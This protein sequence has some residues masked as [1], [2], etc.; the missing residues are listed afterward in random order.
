MNF[1]K[2][3]IIAICMLITTTSISVV[4][5]KAED[6]EKVTSDIVGEWQLL[7]YGNVENPTP[8]M[9]DVKAS[10]TFKLEGTFGGNVG[11][12]RFGGNYTVNDDY[13]SFNNIISTEMYCEETWDQEQGVLSVFSQPD[14]RIQLN[15]DNLT[16]T[17]SIYVLNLRK[18]FTNIIDP[19]PILI[20]PNVDIWYPTMGRITYNNGNAKGTFVHFTIDENTGI[21]YDYT[22]KLTFYPQVWY[23]PVSSIDPYREKE[24]ISDNITYENKVI[25]NSIKINGFEPAATPNV[26]ADFLIFQGKNTF[27]RF[28]DQEGGSVYFASSD[29]NTKITFEIPDGF[30]ISKLTDDYYYSTPATDEKSGEGSNSVISEQPIDFETISS[31]WQTIWI[32]S[33]NTTTSIN[34][35]NGTATINGQTIEVEL[36]PYGYLDIYTYV[37]YPAPPVVNDFWYDDLNIT[38][39]Q[40]IIE[41]AKRNG[42]ISAEGW[43]TNEPT[44][45]PSAAE[46]STDWE[47]VKIA[48]TA[49]NNYY[50][51]DDPTFEMTFNNV[52][53]NG[54]DVV[55]NSQIP[56]GRIVII[57]VDK[58]VIQNTS[59]EKLLVSIDD[60]KINQVTTLEDLM[61]KVENKDAEGAYYALSGERL[62]TVFVYVPHLSTHTIS[63]KSITSGIASVSNV[64]IPIILSVLFIC[65]IIGGIIIKKRKQQ[66][67]F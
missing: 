51:Y 60:S 65:L 64:I 44:M 39:E 37:E 18:G 16:I 40:M 11:C 33:D 1:K 22:V 49:S 3:A 28:F 34:S 61:E 29:K 5:A 67:D 66:D 25:F 2:I 42:T 54:V 30:E 32:K 41:D 31:P 36:S 53:N 10:I 52:D 23:N 48:N 55:V 19:E 58:E 45:V 26:F 47:Q 17:N 8:A 56:N 35:Y 21:I 63:I 7:S 15:N 13:I 57:N 24:I 46:Q 14:L 27:M 12:N 4:I 38:R 62:T 20:T 9:D 50:T 6:T 43:V 59:I